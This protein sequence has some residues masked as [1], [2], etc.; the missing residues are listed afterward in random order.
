MQLVDAKKYKKEIKQLYVTAFPKEERAPILVLYHKT[1]DK[2][3]HFYAVEEKDEFAGL[4]YTIQD[5]GM[6]YVFFLAIA[7]GKRGQGYGTKVLSTLKEMYP[8][9]TITLMIEDTA[10]TSA[11]N[12]AQRVQR[13]GFYKK[14]GFLQLNIR[15]NEAGVGYEL[16]GTN[17]NVTQADFLKLMRN[18]VGG[19][20][21]KWLY[22]KTKLE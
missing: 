14:N 11:D 2:R 8:D 1:K 18:Y 19:I 13:L 17:E 15:I 16:L 10:D 9:N 3:N 6:V 7:E 21:F 4:V 20:L 5:V 22:K 12:Y